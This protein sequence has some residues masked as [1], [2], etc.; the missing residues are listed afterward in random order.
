MLQKPENNMFDNVNNVKLYTGTGRRIKYILCL[1]LMLAVLAFCSGCEEEGSNLYLD[2]AA[3]LFKEGKYADAETAFLKAI[4]NGEKNLTV[5]SGY[6]FNQLKAGDTEGAKA[7]FEL[8]INQNN[9][10]GNY[11]DREPDT[12]EAVRKGLLQI[13]L[14]ENNYEG[15][16]SLLKELGENTQDTKESTKYKA[17][18]ASLAFRVYND[19]KAEAEADTS[20][21]GVKKPSSIY[22]E[23][24]VIAL[25]T[26]A[27]ESGNEDLK[28]YMM[29]ADMYWVKGEK[30]LWE[31]DERRII[32]L[33]DYALDEY[34]AIYGMYLEEKTDKEILKLVDDTE[35]YLKGH[36]AYIDDYSQ[37]IP[38][39]LKAADL[40][41]HE[42]WE[43][44]SAYY[45]DLA[46]Q[47][48][49]A[50]EDKN[51]SDNQIL[52]YQIIVAERKGKMELAYKL[53]G[54][55]LEHCPDDRMAYKEQK[56]LENRLGITVE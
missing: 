5:F 15:A 33:K 13:Y 11:F 42:E 7:L 31:A 22:R 27:I 48:I 3:K 50:A 49:K 28:L 25:V 6:A 51:A 55:Y 1:V 20:D 39:I 29:R 10:Y 16:V 17:E 35:Y 21:G 47:Y 18:A 14:S 4:R 30:D 54:V 46:E 36:A 8:M 40:S 12:G 52:K 26:D 38:M 37:I 24:D 32:E 2:D 23:D 41:T 44:D 53:L 56:Y 34:N 43:H 45:F 19:S 9:T